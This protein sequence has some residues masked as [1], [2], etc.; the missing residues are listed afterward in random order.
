MKQYLYIAQGSLEPSKCKIG[1]TNDLNRRLKEYNSTTGISAENSY[2]YLFAAEVSDMKALEQDIKNRFFY[3]RELESREIYFYN[4]SL[5]E[6]YVS[7]IWASPYFLKKVAL[8]ENKKSSTI[9]PKTQPTMEE[10]GIEQRIEI[11]NRAKRV[12]DDEFYTRMEDIEAELAMYPTKI[13]KDKVVFCNCDD[14]IG[15]RRDYAD[16]SAF[17]LYFLKH[18]FKL[19]LKKLI[20]T[21]YGGPV[22][23][24][25]ARTGPRGYIFTR[26]GV[27]EMRDSPNNYTGSFDSEL[28]LKILN[29]EADIVCTNPPF[30]RAIDYWKVLIKSKKKF[31]IIS[32]VTI[33]ISTAFIP[34]FMQKKAWAGYTSVDWYL[35]LK[36]IPVRAAGHFFTNFPIKDR[37]AIKRL[38]FVPLNEI[39]DVYQRYDDSGTLLVDN[40]FIPNDY[41]KPFAVSTRQ[42]LNGVLECGYEI[43]SKKQYEAFI[44]GKSNFKRVLIQKIKEN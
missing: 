32:N 3:L 30:S 15:E 24:F 6:M 18:F 25:N 23:L 34:Y 29:E 19:K 5:F 41:D 21:H 42:I 22:D 36:R 2:S 38:K 17:A 37:P 10:R 33:P 26:E 39:P 43:V 20:C 1:I 40:N 4:P 35:N 13:W 14:A 9:K 8:K 16:T 44:N 12:K 28:S 11:L 27:T 31:I 7:F